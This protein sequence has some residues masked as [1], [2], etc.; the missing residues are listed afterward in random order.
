MPR[1][2]RW[3]VLGDHDDAERM[4]LFDDEKAADAI[5]LDE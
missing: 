5:S 2:R 1:L 3:S 4:L